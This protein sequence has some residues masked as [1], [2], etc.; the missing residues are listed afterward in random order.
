L[1]DAEELWNS[2][3]KSL[4]QASFPND[5]LLDFLPSSD[6]NWTY[7]KSEWNPT[8]T[9]MCNFTDETVLPNVTGSGN[10]SCHDPIN[11]FPVYRETYDPSWLNTSQYRY[12]SVFDSFGAGSEEN[13]PFTDVLLFVTLQSDPAI[14]D[15]WDT[16]NEMLKLSVSVLHVQNF[17]VVGDEWFAQRDSSKWLPVGPVGNASYTRFECSLT[18]KTE[19]PDESM[20]PWVWQNDTYTLAYEYAT[21]FNYPFIRDEV[22]NI[23]FPTPTSQELFR[24]YQAYMLSIGTNHD[25]SPVHKEVSVWMNIV[26]VSIV[27]L[28]VVAISTGLILWLSGRYLVFL[29]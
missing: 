13:S 12:D 4:D 22:L 24:F 28:V 7:V 25:F 17:F 26:Q 29:L 16:N 11:A 20:I 21:Y 5:Q 19:V 10:T 6:L 8:W 1:E 9:A 2:T 14:N 3:I 27:F 18:R 23:T 15:R